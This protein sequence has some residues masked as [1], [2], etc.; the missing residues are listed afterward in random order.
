MKPGRVCKFT[1]RVVS[2]FVV[3]L[4]NSQFAVGKDWEEGAGYLQLI[5][6]LDRPQDGYCL[7]IIGSG[8]HLRFDLP[9]IAHNCKPGLYADEAIILDKNG[10]IRFPAF[11][12]CVTVVGLNKRSLPGASLMPRQ[13]GE[14]IPF[15]M[16]KIFRNFK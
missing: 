9:L 12:K 15:F 6:K 3:L 4:L 11:D 5:D 16:Q 10:Y 1:F 2:I 7:D 13:C 14:E 8:Q